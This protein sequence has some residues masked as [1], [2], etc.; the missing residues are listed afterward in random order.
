MKEVQAVE[1]IT[2]RTGII[3]VTD[4]MAAGVIDQA[5]RLTTSQILPFR[6]GSGRYSHSFIQPTTVQ[7][8]P[9]S[10]ASH[11]R[12]W[13]ETTAKDPNGKPTFQHDGVFF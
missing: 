11:S 4:T 6:A 10:Q 5:D 7:E 12:R 8:A 3:T 9:L 2:T 13:G 1:R